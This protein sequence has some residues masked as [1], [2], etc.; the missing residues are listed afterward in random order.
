MLTDL[1]ENHKYNND[2]LVCV[3]ESAVQACVIHLP[4]N[5]HS[6]YNSLHVVLLIQQIVIIA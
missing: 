5:G 6:I 1:R 4:S 3:I 2:Y